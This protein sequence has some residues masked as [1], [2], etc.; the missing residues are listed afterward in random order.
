MFGNEIYWKARRSMRFNKHLKNVAAEFRITF[1][2]STDERD[3][4]ILPDDWLQ[5]K[6]FC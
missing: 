5:E 2:N 3:N 1:L 4:T 6:V